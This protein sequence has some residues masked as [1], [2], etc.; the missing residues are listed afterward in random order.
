MSTLTEQERGGAGHQHWLQQ[1]SCS[2][3][4]ADK[5]LPGEGAGQP[6]VYVL[7]IAVVG[8]ASSPMAGL[9]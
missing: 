5:V 1:D 8:W 4:G 9:T 6:A 2:S 7:L 3:S